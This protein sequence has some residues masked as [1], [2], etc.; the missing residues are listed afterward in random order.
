MARLAAEERI[1]GIELRLGIYEMSEANTP[2]VGRTLAR[3][4]LQSIPEAHCYLV[5][6]GALVDVTR[7]G[8]RGKEPIDRFVVEETIRPDQIG[9]Y[10]RAFHRGFLSERVAQGCYG[11]RTT[12][13]LW[14]IREACIAALAE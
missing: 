4:G 12:E 5:C 3:Y 13:E 6:H 1:I 14:E 9:D 11:T 10:K 7:T 2:G 8:G